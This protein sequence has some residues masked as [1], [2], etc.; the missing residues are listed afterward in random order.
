MVPWNNGFNI[1]H[2]PFRA[3]VKKQQQ[4]QY[5]LE[6]AEEALSSKVAQR[7]AVLK[8]IQADSVTLTFL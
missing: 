2:F 8:E 1:G 5:E 7:D 6:K 4:K 3:V